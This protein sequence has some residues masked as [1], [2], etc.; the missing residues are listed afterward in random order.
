MIIGI[1]IDSVL[2]SRIERLMRERGDQFLKKI[3][4]EAV[5]FPLIEAMAKR[6]AEDVKL[7]AKISGRTAEDGT[8]ELARN[9]DLLKTHL[10]KRR[11]FLLDQE[12]LAG[13]Q[14]TRPLE[15]RGQFLPRSRAP[16]K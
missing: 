5:Y 3:Y 16:R 8:R 9:V 1:G 14:M 12:E 7:R 2:I 10:V 6:L 15:S 11:T 13:T 4:T